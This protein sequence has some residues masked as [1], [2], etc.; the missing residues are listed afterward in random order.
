MRRI[1]EYADELPLDLEE[2]NTLLPEEMR[3]KLI[4]FIREFHE[5]NPALK[6]IKFNR[7]FDALVQNE[8]IRESFWDELFKA[9]PELFDNQ[10][11]CRRW[12]N[13]YLYSELKPSAKMEL[14]P[15]NEDV[16]IN[17]VTDA[18]MQ[19]SDQWI[20]SM[21]AME[22]E[23]TGEQEEINLYVLLNNDDAADTFFVMNMLD[24]M[25][26]MPGSKTHLKK[27][28]MIR[29]TPRQMAGIIRDD[30]EGFGFTKLFHAIRSFLNYGKADMIVDIWKKSGEH[31]ECLE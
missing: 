20:D 15:I 22:K 27:L 28:F 26:T 3:Q 18:N 6:N 30:T 4:S 5:G 7:L 14:L 12:V 1:A 25:L 19:D 29:N 31:N 11:L 21:M 2:E 17:F 9:C 13:S 23:I 10:D 24:I 16:C 8:E